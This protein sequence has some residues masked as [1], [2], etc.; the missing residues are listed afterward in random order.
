MT[1]A[2][3]GQLAGEGA[4]RCAGR[5]RDH[6][7]EGHPDRQRGA[8]VLEGG[9][10]WSARPRVGRTGAAG[11]W[12]WERAGARTNLG[13]LGHTAL[14]LGTRYLALTASRS[15][16]ETGTWYSIAV[17]RSASACFLRSA[18]AKTAGT[19]PRGR[20]L[21]GCG[22]VWVHG[23]GLGGCED[24]AEYLLFAGDAPAERQP[25]G[26]QEGLFGGG[27]R[28]A[29]LRGERRRL[30]QD[31]VEK[32]VTGQDE[33]DQTEL[34]GGLGPQHRHLPRRRRHRRR[35]DRQ[36]HPHGNPGECPRKYQVCSCSGGR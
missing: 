29:G 14:S 8:G 15:G 23:A 11:E 28:V 30:V 5:A 12:R 25:G 27:E 9:R 35:P 6:Q 2:V 17:S 34:E 31:R 3:L 21:S 26:K 16:T 7:G 33:V 13:E 24:G 22:R 36:R 20:S 32:A 4:R 10:T 18:L 19:E 1:D